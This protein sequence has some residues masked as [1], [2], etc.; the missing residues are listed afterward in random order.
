MVARQADPLI[1]T[2]TSV[3]IERALLRD[4]KIAAVEGDVTVNS[5]ILDGIR[6]VLALHQK[7]MA[8]GATKGIT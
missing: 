1:W 2:S 5:L 3:R 4:L 7:Q 6:R 8:R